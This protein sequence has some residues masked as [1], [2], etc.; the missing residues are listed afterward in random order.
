MQFILCFTTTVILLWKAFQVMNRP[1]IFSSQ[2]SSEKISTERPNPFFCGTILIL[3]VRKT[4][5]PSKMIWESCVVT[6]SLQRDQACKG[7]NLVFPHP[8]A[9]RHSKQ[10]FILQSKLKEKSNQMHQQKIISLISLSD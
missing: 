3:K 2:K 5:S 9:D 8:S 10:R 4:C 7:L 6:A 1:A